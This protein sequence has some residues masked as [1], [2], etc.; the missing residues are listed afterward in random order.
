MVP[1]PAL[2]QGVERLLAKNVRELPGPLG[3]FRGRRRRVPGESLGESLR[4]RGAGSDVFGGRRRLE[5]GV[6]DSVAVLDRLI[7]VVKIAE[8]AEIFGGFVG[9]LVIILAVR[10]RRKAGKVLDGIGEIAGFAGVQASDLGEGLR[11]DRPEDSSG[12]LGDP[13]FR[14]DFVSAGGTGRRAS[15]HLA[16]LGVPVNLRIMFPEPGI[17]KDELLLA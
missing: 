2:R 13:A 16:L 10:V 4:D 5:L 6:E 15:T 7:R 1:S 17:S 14:S 11:T 12:G 3:D 9:V 8:I